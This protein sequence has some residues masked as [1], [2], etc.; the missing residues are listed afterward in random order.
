MLSLLSFAISLFLSYFSFSFSV[1]ILLLLW[2]IAWT[3]DEKGFFYC[4]YPTPQ[5]SA[6]KGTETDANLNMKVIK[7]IQRERKVQRHF[8]DTSESKRSMGGG[9]VQW[10]FLFNIAEELEGKKQREGQR[11]SQKFPR[12]FQQT[13][14]NSQPSINS[15]FL[16]SFC[17]LFLFWNY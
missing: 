6:D 8:K 14:F 13:V 15:F 3:H 2:S 12:N 17:R 1:L 4:R 16:F 9:K 5:N 11:E 7:K 10:K